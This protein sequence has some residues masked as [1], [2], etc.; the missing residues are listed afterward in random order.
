MSSLIITLYDM[1]YWCQWEACSFLKGN[2]G[3]VVLGGRGWHAGMRRG[4][5]WNQDAICERIRK[6]NKTEQKQKLKTKGPLLFFFSGP[7]TVR[8]DIVHHGSFFW[9]CSDIISLFKL[10][11]CVSL[12]VFLFVGAC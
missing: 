10:G 1:F 8:Q 9:L 3:R 11:L 5:I 2:G 7:F 6:E 12:C 4:K